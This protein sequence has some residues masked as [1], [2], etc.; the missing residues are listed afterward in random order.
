ML[1]IKGGT[2]Y[3]ITGGIIKDG[4]I[5]VDN[6]KIVEVGKNVSIPRSRSA[7]RAAVGEIDEDPGGGESRDVEPLYHRGIPGDGQSIAACGQL[8]SIEDDVRFSG[9]VIRRGSPVNKDLVCNRG[10]RR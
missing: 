3:T 1:A 2:I 4:V 6:G 9:K 8:A 7:D 5:L 10:E